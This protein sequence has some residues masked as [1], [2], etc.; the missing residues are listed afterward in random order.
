MLSK[1]GLA[2]IAIAGTIAL[3]GGIGAGTYAYFTSQAT[4]T[5]NTITAG[6]LE[7][8]RGNSNLGEFVVTDTN[9]VY[10]PG[11]IVTMDENKKP[12]AH[13]F[14]IENSGNLNLAYLCNFEFTGQDTELANAIYI[15]NL[16]RTYKGNKELIIS[17]GKMGNRL[18]QLQD[19][20]NKQLHIDKYDANG[21]KDTDTRISLMEWINWNN[22]SAGLSC[23][24]GLGTLGI[25]EGESK[26]IWEVELV[27]D[28]NAGDKYNKKDLDALVFDYEVTATQPKAEALIQIAPDKMKQALKQY[29]E[30]GKLQDMIDNKLNQ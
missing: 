5:G 3:G 9:K 16:K 12:G 13:K 4:S 26:E 10:Q 25:L 6:R 15:R 20:D 22:D 27:F 7:I 24:Y 17:E 11:D 1:K 19:A 23:G 18:Q 2:A 21:N 28:E 8:N 30:D 29:N 14:T